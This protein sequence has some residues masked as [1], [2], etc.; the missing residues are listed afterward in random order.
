MDSKRAGTIAIFSFVLL[1]LIWGLLSIMP[2]VV[3]KEGTSDSASASESNRPSVIVN[4][5][6]ADSM[7]TY[8]GVIDVPTPCHML[9]SAT[10]VDYSEP[11]HVSVSLT[12]QQPLSACAEVVTQQKFSTTVSSDVT[13]ILAISINGV[14]AQPIILEEK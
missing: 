3:S 6:S 5:K 14:E 4:H 9:E 11:A 7:H 2:D 13:P 1:S 10:T 8:T 12:V